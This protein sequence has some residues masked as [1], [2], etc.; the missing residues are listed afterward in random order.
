MSSSFI[1]V[2]N[3]LFNISAIHYS[4]ALFRAFLISVCTRWPVRQIPAA[5]IFWYWILAI[6]PVQHDNT[7]QLYLLVGV[8]L[9]GLIPGNQIMRRTATDHPD[10]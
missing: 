9:K 1:Y 8:T 4:I 5:L 3:R 7:K 10:L 2:C 6:E